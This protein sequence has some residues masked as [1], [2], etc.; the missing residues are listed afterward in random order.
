MIVSYLINKHD[1]YII[2]NLIF[3]QFV[4]YSIYK[5]IYISYYYIRILDRSSALFSK[6]EIYYSARIIL[7]CLE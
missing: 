6:H 5:Y 2:Y 7:H 4:K 1:L 3:Q